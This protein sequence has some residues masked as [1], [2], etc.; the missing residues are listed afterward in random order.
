[1]YLMRILQGGANDD[2]WITDIKSA[3]GGSGLAPG[4]RVRPGL[5]LGRVRRDRLARV[6]HGQGTPAAGFEVPVD[7][8]DRST[9][10]WTN[11]CR[12]E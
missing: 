5:A 3:R 7:Q 12:P 6:G 10:A 2:L 11:I 9:A 4:G 1:M 8:H